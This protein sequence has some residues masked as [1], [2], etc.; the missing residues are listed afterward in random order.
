M[1]K[2]F[3]TFLFAICL[4][5]P[6]AFIMTA[7]GGDPVE[8]T[9]N[10][11]TIYIKDEQTNEFNCV[12]GESAIR[13]GDVKIKSNWSD[14]SKDSFVPLNDFELS[15]FWCNEN[16]EP[17]TTLPDFWTNS[18][19]TSGNDIATTYQFTLTKDDLSADFFVHIGRAT[20]QNARIWINAGGVYK[21]SAEM[22]WNHNYRNESNLDKLFTSEIEG[23]E[24]NYTTTF[25]GWYVVSDTD[26]YDAL[27]TDDQKKAYVKENAQECGSKDDIFYYYTPGKYYIFANAPAGT[28]YYYGE[29][30]D[31]WIYNYATLNIV[32][33]QIKQQ[34]NQVHVVNYD[35]RWSEPIAVPYQLIDTEILNYDVYSTNIAICFYENEQWN[36][37]DFEGGA[38][39]VHAIKNGDN[40]ELVDFANWYNPSQGWVYINA[41]GSKGVT[42][43]APSQIEIVDYYRINNYINSDSYTFPV[44]YQIK[45]EQQDVYYDYSAMFRTQVQINKCKIGSAPL[46]EPDSNNE[47]YGVTG[48]NTFTFTYGDAW[49]QSK[50]QDAYGI[51]SDG[52]FELIIPNEYNAGSH[53]AQI[54][55]KNPNFAWECANG[56]YSSLPVS[57]TYIINK[58][59]VGVPTYTLEQTDYHEYYEDTIKIEYTTT[60]FDTYYI[61]RYIKGAA[62]ATIYYYTFESGDELLTTPQLIEKIKEEGRQKNTLLDSVAFYD[63]ANEVGKKVA[64]LIDLP[65]VHNYE[66]EDDS[67]GAKL[68]IFEIVKAE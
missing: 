28:N 45:Q 14:S 12:F 56:Y 2:K 5:L 53:T 36:A 50:M 47:Q 38:I 68:F 26:A 60:N 51:S 29:D 62:N 59:E 23:L 49:I 40:Y 61:N 13:K 8:P 55:L 37:Y 46:I 25:V 3:L 39:K 31:G 18:T 4:M 63:N 34:R 21:N 24:N 11:Y 1:K 52:M 48:T 22:E 9:L 6:C 30:G 32:N 33:A 20:K 67:T 66:W 15:V 16:G 65:D 41:D 17:Q 42:V 27:E 64:I 43:D 35:A 7:C 19:G 44:Y 54:V 58:V 57:V 10:G